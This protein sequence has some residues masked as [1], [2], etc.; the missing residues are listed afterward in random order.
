MVTTKSTQRLRIDGVRRRVARWRQMRPHAHAP[1]PETLWA[2]AVALTRQH[3]LYQ[4]ARALGVDYGALKRHVEGA[5]T[6]AH[7]KP[8]FVEL[9]PH[10][11]GGR[12]GECVME[13]DGPRATVRV[14]VPGL[15]LPDL[16]TLG[17]LLAGV[18]S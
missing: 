17:R 10:P 18:E 3:G 6:T 4:T 15:A 11:P 7:A 1:M 9:P 13:I 8:M 14:R 12:A 2:A 16:A 5:A